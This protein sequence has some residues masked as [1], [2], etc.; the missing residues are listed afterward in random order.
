MPFQ[1]HSDTQHPAPERALE[2][3]VVDR[4]GNIIS[5]GHHLTTTMQVRCVVRTISLSG[6]VLEV[7]KGLDI[8]QNFFL[9]ILGIHDEIGCTLL[10]RNGTVV[11][12]CFNMLIS[13]DFLH[14][15][16]RLN[17]EEST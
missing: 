14:H 4:P 15:V 7:N 16:Q 1:M 11:T 3:F 8:P 12:V 6:A 17:F 13:P 5:I 2:E 10:K 9:E